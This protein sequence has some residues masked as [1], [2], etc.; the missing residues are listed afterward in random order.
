MK[1][2]RCMSY[3]GHV[4]YANEYG[5]MVASGDGTDKYFETIYEAMEYIEEIEH[6]KAE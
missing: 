1:D 6:I 4:I 2:K 5:Y 3:F